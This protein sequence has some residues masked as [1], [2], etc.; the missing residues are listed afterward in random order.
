MERWLKEENLIRRN[1][2]NLN[3]TMWTLCDDFGSQQKYSCRY[4]MLHSR[5]GSQL[6]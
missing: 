6:V 2:M 3:Q 4:Y 5:S 1:L